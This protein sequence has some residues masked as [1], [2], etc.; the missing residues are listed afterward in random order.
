V[1]TI[2][3]QALDDAANGVWGM[4]VSITAYVL[5]A[6]VKDLRESKCLIKLEANDADK[7]EVECQSGIDYCSDCGLYGKHCTC[8]VEPDS[9]EICSKVLPF[10]RSCGYMEDICDCKSKGMI[11]DTI[12]DHWRT[13]L[14]PDCK[15]YEKSCW[16]NVSPH[17]SEVPK[18]KRNHIGSYEEGDTRVHIVRMTDEQWFAY[19]RWRDMKSRYVPQSD[20][21]PVTHMDTQ[22]IS[23]GPGSHTE[24]NVKFV[25]T[26]PGYTLEEKGSFDPVRD[27]ALE[28]D[29]TLDEFF[30]RPIKIASYDWAVGGGG[31][32]Q[33]FNPWSLY[34]EN[35]R[36]INRISNY[37][38]MRSK[39]HIKATISGNGFH[40]GRC[41]LTYNPFP[42]KDTLTVDRTFV[43]PDF[44]AAS[45]RPHIYLDPTNSQGGELI[46]PFFYYKNVMDIT[47]SDWQQMGELVLAD[48]QD[49]KHAN[50]A[51]DTVTINIF[52][53]AEEAK[54]AIPTHQEPNT[55]SAQAD[56]YGKGPISRVAGVV[57]AAAGKLTSIPPIAPF[58]R[59]TEIG[60]GAAGALATLFG[61]SRPVMLE[62]CQYR[63]N[64]KGSFA[65]TNAS[66]DVMKLTVDQK[67]ELSIDPRTAGLDNVDELG[68]NYIAGRESYY[69]QFPWAVGTGDESLLWNCV[70]DPGL[71][72]VDGTAYAL[73]AC[74]FAALP[75]KFWRGSMK[76]RFQVVCSKYHKG[77]LKIVYD[78]AGT[79]GSTAE[80][81]TAYTT[82]VDIADTTDFTVTVGWG[83]ATSYRESI[84]VASASESIIQNTSALSYDSSSASYG[85][86]TI[87][88]YVVNELT[89]PDSTIDNDININVFMSAGDDFEVAVPEHER[90][91]RMRF[92]NQS[93]LVQPQ[94]DEI[95]PQAN[96]V[97]NTG[98]EQDRIDSKPHHTANINTMSALTTLSDQTNHI[99]FGESIRSFRQL[100]KRYTV[101]EFPSISGTQND[102]I[103]HNFRRHLLPF[104]PGYTEDSSSLSTTVNV[105]TTDDEY[106]YGYM[107]LPRYLSA[108]YGGWKGGMRYVWDFS[109]MNANTNRR[110]GYLV[111]AINNDDSNTTPTNSATNLNDTT[112]VAG[113]ASQIL[114]NYDYSGMDGCTMQSKVINPTVNFEVPY[115]SEY[116]FTPAKQRVDYDTEMFAM[117]MYNVAHYGEKG[118]T[119]DSVTVWC[120]AAEDFTCF[121]FLGAPLLYYEGNSVPS[122]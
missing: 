54:F 23:M 16:C 27:H 78:P 66:D 55:I 29:A 65:V 44:V 49:L 71:F 89:V 95:I 52:A 32:H 93:N 118:D 39:L 40:Y 107:T 117:P 105:G 35:P 20:E 77:R 60:A 103:I 8:Y 69:A 100:L 53:W 119:S 98:D 116:R 83:Q 88:V 115:Y 11:P 42:D 84:P 91:A 59:A 111:A 19:R 12:Q 85:N 38:L 79:A 104:E 48:L 90:L 96:E 62:H 51:S 120:A 75:F 28:S 94:S 58:A 36:V 63:P 46:L 14:C 67:Q 33:Q 92:T 68:I 18:P 56:E 80:Y 7:S 17:S 41:V 9:A 82:I 30:Q 109:R 13:N 10:C 3:P 87:A 112:T 21:V 50:G 113:K 114:A 97:P 86:G 57:A 70:V 1:D 121:M 26:H 122:S 72:R 108:A 99:H 15:I 24:Q 22:P 64:T 5:Y 101:H 102:A 61:Y 34:F 110:K 43:E 47:I 106:V 6:L 76:F 73:P 74:S 31:L 37:K 2:V 4:F 25:D 45:Q 81:N